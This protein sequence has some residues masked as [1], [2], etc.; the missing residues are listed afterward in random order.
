MKYSVSFGTIT[1]DGNPATGE[2]GMILCTKKGTTIDLQ[3]ENYLPGTHRCL[4]YWQKHDARDNFTRKYYPWLE[5]KEARKL[6][7]KLRDELI[8]ECMK[9]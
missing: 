4:V 9:E 3:M 7:L 8:A 5:E 1:F 6:W 2:K